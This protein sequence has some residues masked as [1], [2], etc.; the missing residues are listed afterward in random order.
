MNIP[1][2]TSNVIIY[3]KPILISISFKFQT[4]FS[5]YYTLILMKKLS[6]DGFFIIK[7]IVCNAHVLPARC[8]IK[9]I[10]VGLGDKP[11]PLL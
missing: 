7:F 6:R 4:T 3:F 10:R 5:N 8:K 11:K 2:H 9:V 1:S